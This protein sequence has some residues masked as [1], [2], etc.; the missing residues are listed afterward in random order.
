MAE[1]LLVLIRWLSTGTCL[2]W[3]TTAP[4]VSAATPGTGSVQGQIENSVTQRPIKDAVIRLMRGGVLAHTGSS[5]AQ[6]R[7]I[8]SDVPEGVY[9]LEVDAPGHMKA[10]QAEVRVV[11]NKAAT[12]EFLLVQVEDRALEEVIVAAR[13]VG[14]DPR[15]SPNTLLLDRE[16][17]RRNPGSAGDVFRALDMLPGVVATGEFSTSRSEA[18]GRVTI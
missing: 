14:N 11:L 10:V 17:I 6:G 4:V 9:A 12:V 8:F 7:F 2:L 15:L 18:T 3:L 13:A 1:E 16:E 5:D